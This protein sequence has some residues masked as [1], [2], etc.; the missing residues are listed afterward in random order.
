MEGSPEEDNRRRRNSYA[1]SPTHSHPYSPIHGVHPQSPYNQ[2]SSRP[3]TSATM[4]LPSAISPRLGPP[5]SPKMNGPS[6]NGAIYS[7][8]ETGRSTRYDPIS[9]HREGHP[10]WKQP[11]YHT[12]SPKEVR[13]PSSAMAFQVV[14]N[15]VSWMLTVSVPKTREHG[16]YPSQYD[17]SMTSPISYR[18]PTVPHFSHHSPT[19]PTPHGHPP[20]RRDSIPQPSARGALESPSHPLSNHSYTSQANGSMDRPSSQGAIAEKMVEKFPKPSPD[21]RTAR[22]KDPMAFANILSS[23][24]PDPPKPTLQ[25]TPVLK[26]LKGSSYAPNGDAKPSTATS[27]TVATKATSSLKGHGGPVKRYVKPEHEPNAHVKGLGNSKPKPGG[28]SDKENEKVKKEM[29]RIDAMETS[30]LECPEFE[31]TKQKHDQVSQK[32]QQDVEATEDVKRKVSG[33]SSLPW[34]PSIVD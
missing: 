33:A 32:R 29:A 10:G 14:F 18:S 9:E 24:D 4:S 30:D 25:S 20:S 11:P 17:E 26:K 6:L 13:R 19:L 21:L 7:D 3:S 15:F 8:R 16:P 22:T 28:T 27:R 5:P 1:Q 12:R 2:Y 34:C 31:H 23:N